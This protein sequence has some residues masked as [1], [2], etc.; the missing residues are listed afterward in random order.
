MRL[1]YVI[2]CV[3]VGYYDGQSPIYGGVTLR[4]GDQKPVTL[5]DDDTE[6]LIRALK[7]MK[8]HQGVV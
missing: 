4:V 2:G 3:T 6:Q 1:Q 5:T 8:N 7:D